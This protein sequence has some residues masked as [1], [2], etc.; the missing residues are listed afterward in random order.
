MSLSL[1]TVSVPRK[2]AHPLFFDLL[3]IP[4][5]LF[6]SP[7]LVIGVLLLNSAAIIGIAIVA[8]RRGGPLAAT[9]ASNPAFVPYC[10]AVS[11]TGIQNGLSGSE[12]KRLPSKKILSATSITPMNRAISTIAE[13]RM[14]A[15]VL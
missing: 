7:G 4:V 15:T 9:A 10:A 2:K 11:R 8:H 1:T 13:I 3:S 5:K 14:P 6:N 12:R